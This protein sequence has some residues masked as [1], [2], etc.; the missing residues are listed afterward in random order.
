MQGI[1]PKPATKDVMHAMHA[2]CVGKGVEQ[3]LLARGALGGGF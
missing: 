3:A 1:F 2:L